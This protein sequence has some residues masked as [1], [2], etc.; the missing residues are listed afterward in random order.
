MENTT[1]KFQNQD[2]V[3]V[4]DKN[5][6]QMKWPLARIDEKKRSCQEKMKL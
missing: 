3:L 6:D 2:L 5:A 4:F 1:K